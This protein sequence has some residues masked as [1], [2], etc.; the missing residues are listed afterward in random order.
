MKKQHLSC[1]VAGHG[2]LVPCVFR[3]TLK[4]VLVAFFCFCRFSS[5][6]RNELK[7]FV[8]GAILSFAKKN[9]T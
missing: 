8:S 7:Q 5:I 9:L 4:Q 3:Q 1:F 6:L 2:T